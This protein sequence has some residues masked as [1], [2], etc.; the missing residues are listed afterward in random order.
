MKELQSDLMDIPGVLPDAP[1]GQHREEPSMLSLLK[2]INHTEEET[3]EPVAPILEETKKRNDGWKDARH[4][5]AEMIGEELAPPSEVDKVLN[6]SYEEE[7]T[8]EVQ[9]TIEEETK[10][11]PKRAVAA[12]MVIK[13]MVQE[14][15]EE[16]AQVKLDGISNI[17][18][19][20]NK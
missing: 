3:T 7:I 9:E 8:E 12:L 10:E 5:Y 14:L 18:N 17:I 6:G 15:N 4:T 1:K 20:F 19:S 13:E 16:T 2:K 11:D